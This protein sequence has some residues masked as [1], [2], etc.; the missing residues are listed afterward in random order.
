MSKIMQQQ[1]IILVDWGY[2]LHTAVYSRNALLRKKEQLENEGE[3]HQ[4]K[5][6]FIVPTTY[7]SMSML[8]GALKKVGVN[9]D[10]DDKVIICCDS[11]NNWRKQYIKTYKGNREKLREQAKFVNWNK[12]FDAH[13]KLLEKIEIGTPFFVISVPT[14]ESDDLIAYATKFF[15]DKLCIIIGSDHDYDQLLTRDNVRIFSPHSKAKKIPYRILSLDREK[16]KKKAYKSLMSKVRKEISD[17]LISE[18]S[19]EREYD[20]RLMLVNLIQQPKFITKRIK[21]IL[22]EIDGIEKEN[23]D[24]SI[25]SNGIQKRFKDIFKSDKIITYSDC[26]KKLEKKINKNR[27]R[28]R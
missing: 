8:I 17:N 11:P 7:T 13:E 15:K 10:T 22:K 12:E 1:K 4:A 24:P 5:K 27:R 25:F 18:I 20:T 28:K 19:N 21:P 23:F 2:F 16:E 9:L 3:Y 26:R 6:L 14:F